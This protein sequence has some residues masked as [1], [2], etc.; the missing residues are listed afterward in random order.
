[1]FGSKYAGLNHLFPNPLQLKQIAS[2]S[3][4]PRL[5]KG[6]SSVVS[7]HEAL[8]LKIRDQTILVLALGIPFEV[9][10][11]ANAVEAEAIVSQ[12]VFECRKVLEEKFPREGLVT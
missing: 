5:N 6:V 4:P 11:V 3:S 7:G 9:H 12:P 1:M 10:L 8:G 2:C